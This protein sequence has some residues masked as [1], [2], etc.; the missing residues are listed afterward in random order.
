MDEAEAK[1]DLCG[2][3][4]L[5]S[6]RD[7][8][9]DDNKSDLGIKHEP[10]NW[11]SC[12]MDRDCWDTRRSQRYEHDLV[13]TARCESQCRRFEESG[14]DDRHVGEAKPLCGDAPVGGELRVFM[15]PTK[16]HNICRQQQVKE[17]GK[18]NRQVRSGSDLKFKRIPPRRNQSDEHWQDKHH[19]NQHN[20]AVQ[21]KSTPMSRNSGEGAEVHVEDSTRRRARP[22]MT[23][24]P[25]GVQAESENN[26][27]ESLF[28]QSGLRCGASSTAAVPH[29]LIKP[30]GS[31]T[32]DKARTLSPA[33]AAE[34]VLVPSRSRER[35]VKTKC[36][37]EQV[38]DPSWQA[39][40][41]GW[42]VA[43]CQS[44]RLFG[45]EVHQH[46]LPR[47]VP[48][49][50][51]DL[52]NYV[53]KLDDKTIDARRAQIRQTILHCQSKLLGVDML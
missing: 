17:T 8:D 31:I 13:R 20:L 33:G 38:S 36:L 1:I 43:T 3:R 9:E 28:C 53:R 26:G 7:E 21:I 6:C 24:H 16:E 27:S 15:A 14:C 37:Q 48:V 2:P 4:S 23:A 25:N 18:G 32:S 30:V 52:A 40:A 42:S 50:A 44:S 47:I 41:L 49:R 34:T 51:K 12:R 5:D 19:L 45:E 46:S 10:E 35:L 29:N 39:D 22:S 11:E